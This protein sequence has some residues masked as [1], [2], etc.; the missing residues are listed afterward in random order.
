PPGLALRSC[1]MSGSNLLSCWWACWRLPRFWPTLLRFTTIPDRLLHDSSPICLTPPEVRTILSLL[2]L[3]SMNELSHD[4]LAIPK[5][6]GR[7]CRVL[8]SGDVARTC[9]GS[10][11]IRKQPPGRNNIRSA[12][13][14]GGRS[15]PAPWRRHQSR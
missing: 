14:Q 6:D 9:H 10:V 2:T 4:Q 12:R 5:H 15:P 11:R 7:E 3:R 1:V 8:G 13:G